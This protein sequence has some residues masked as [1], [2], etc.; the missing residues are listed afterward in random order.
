[1][2]CVTDTITAATAIS[3]N[4]SLSV[5]LPVNNTNAWDN[6]YTAIIMT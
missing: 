1:M 6:V 2:L 5:L 4:I 3:Y